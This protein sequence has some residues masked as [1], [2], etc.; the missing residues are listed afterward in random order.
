MVECMEE[1]HKVPEVLYPLANTIA[2]GMFICPIWVWRRKRREWAYSLIMYGKD[3][4][5]GNLVPGKCCF[6]MEIFAILR[7][8]VSFRWMLTVFFLQKVCRKFTF[9]TIFLTIF[10]GNFAFFPS[11]ITN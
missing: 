1:S 8:S 7:V 5:F 9:L 2:K 3:V 6:W 4:E 10:Q 11:Y